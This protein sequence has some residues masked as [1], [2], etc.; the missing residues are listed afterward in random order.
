MKRVWVVLFVGACATDAPIESQ[1]EAYGTEQQG[2]EQQGTEQQGT[3]Q[4]GTEQQGTE[5]QGGGY[6]GTAYENTKYVS[7]SWAASRVTYNGVAVSSAA[8][9]KTTLELWKH[10]TNGTW[11]QRLPNKICTW[12]SEMSHSTCTTVN[13]ATQ[14]SPLAGAR[15]TSTFKRADGSTFSGV[16][17]IG[18]GPNQ[19][20]AVKVDTSFAAHPL[21]GVNSCTLDTTCDHPTGCRKNCDL[22]V[23]DLRLFNT[24]DSSNQLVKFCP[25][26]DAYPLAGTWDPTGQRVS[27]PSAFTF[28]CMN[29]T[30]AKCTKWGYRPFGSAKNSAGAWESLAGYHQSCVRA[31]KAD[32][33]GIYGSGHSFTKNGTLI[34]IYDYQPH[35]S[36][37]SGF[38]PRTVSYLYTKGLTQTMYVGE[39]GFDNKGATDVELLRYAELIG[40]PTYG[41]LEDPELGCPGLFTLEEWV[42][43]GEPYRARQRSPLDSVGPV[44][45]VDSTA[46]CS[47]TEYET[48]KWLHWSCSAC[49]KKLAENQSLAYC[50]SPI[51]RWDAACTAGAAT[52]CAAT[53]RMGYRK[54]L[55]SVL[56]G[57][58]LAGAQMY[59]Y[60]SSCT[61]RICEARASCC[62]S[63]WD[64]TCVSLANQRCTGGRER[65][66]LSGDY[67]FCGTQLPPTNAGG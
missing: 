31:A 19:V 48:G 18:S 11:T 55:T 34:D 21:D 9:N 37:Q 27:A 25:N 2:T 60:G 45:R 36:S 40:T 14:P 23:Y 67:G 63:T 50:T 20:G 51:G 43:L 35:D 33:C 62:E 1:L 30:I 44:V 46:A 22:F 59:K 54:P 66:T 53:E 39:A 17:Q 64:A 42:P 10:N 58:C 65:S 38:I 28:A 52:S 56:H 3:E 4:Q 15:F 16:I 12:D 47:H 29:G 24:Y 57:E 8:L 13:L 61:Y 7:S 5:Q 6:V 26:T 49:T 41:S 32:Y